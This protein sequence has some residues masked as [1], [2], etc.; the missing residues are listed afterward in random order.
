MADAVAEGAATRLGDRVGDG[1][2]RPDVVEDRRAR[3]RAQERAREQRGDEVA[4]REL[5]VL[6][7][8]E[9]AVGVAVE[10][11]AEVGAALADLGDDRF[12]VLGEQR[13]GLVEREV[14]SGS[15]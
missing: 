10:G 12:A 14:P 1:A 15:Q 9:A 7:D 2:A 5:A 3:V 6:V 13:V 4:R 8:E 11:D